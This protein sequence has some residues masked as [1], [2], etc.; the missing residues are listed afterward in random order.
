M[1]QLIFISTLLIV[2]SVNVF[3]QD[4]ETKRTAEERA[5]FQT[6]WMKQSLGLS[7]DQQAQVDPLNLKYAR[8]MDGVKNISGKFAKLKKAKS[9]M[10]EKDKELKKILNKDQY[11][12]YQ[13]KKEE[14]LE[15]M[16]EANQQRK[17]G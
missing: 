4:F 8:Q 13:D 15:K 16:K 6:E 12:L 5:R 1:K 7:D 10:D 11:Q 9:I 3:A 2:L 14:L 17:N